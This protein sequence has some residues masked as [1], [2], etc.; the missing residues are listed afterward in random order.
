[1]SVL[2]ATLTEYVLPVAVLVSAAATTSTAAFAWRL[3]SLSR[4]HD[5]ALFGEEEV[6]GHDGIIETVNRNQRMT[7]EH[8]QTLRREGM[9]PAGRVYDG[10]DDARHPD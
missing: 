1:M 7:R 8:R 10:D 4:T 3:W 9:T 5:R 6:D 2:P